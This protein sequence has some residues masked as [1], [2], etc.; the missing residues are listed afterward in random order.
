MPGGVK[1]ERKKEQKYQPGSSD[2][3]SS[4]NGNTSLVKNKVIKAMLTKCSKINNYSLKS[5]PWDAGQTYVH[6]HKNTAAA[7]IGCV[8]RGGRPIRMHLSHRNLPTSLFSRQIKTLDT[9][10]LVD[11]PLLGTTIGSSS[12]KRGN[13]NK[14]NLYCIYTRSE[15]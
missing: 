4:L 6:S 14:N 8:E 10:T 3:N 12:V 11:R 9:G 5:S 1:K 15:V 7:V 2:A 13:C